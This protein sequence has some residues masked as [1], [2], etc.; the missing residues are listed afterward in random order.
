MTDDT[1]EIATALMR[2]LEVAWNRADGP[3]FAAPFTDDADFVD[4]RADYHKGRPEIAEGHVRILTGIFKDS[5][6]KYELLAARELAPGV[7]GAQVR[8]TLQVPTGPM[9]GEN[10]A[11]FSFVAVKHGEQW[12]IEQFHNTLAP[13]QRT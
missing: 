1:T 9:A 7:I 6:N 13:P 10:R 12:Q 8:S 4:I 3:G 11:V 2:Q 5:V